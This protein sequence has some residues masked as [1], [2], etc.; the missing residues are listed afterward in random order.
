MGLHGFAVSGWILY[1]YIYSFR[2][3]R[4]Q[5]KID[6]MTKTMTKGSR[7]QSA[8][9]YLM[10]YGWAI[11]IIAVVLAALFSLNV[12]NAGAQLGTSCIGRP[13]F[14][15][16]QPTIT[17]SG[18][19]SFILGQG[20]GYTTY[21]AQIAC[22]SSANSVSANSLIFNALGGTGG[23]ANGIVIAGGAA[24]GSSTTTLANQISSGTT[25]PITGLQCFPGTGAVSGTMLYPIGS[26]FTGVI[27]LAHSS[28]P[29]GGQ[30]QYI[31]IATVSVKSSS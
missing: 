14:S 4:Y 18:T 13:G 25:L 10:T 2:T 17:Q 7:A 21:N 26:A 9:E 6:R 27:W 22:V 24:G 5:Q 15:C 30:I 11:L 16:S 23:L 31:K 20:V 28:T 29:T 3:F 1:I 19:L 8:M 12:F